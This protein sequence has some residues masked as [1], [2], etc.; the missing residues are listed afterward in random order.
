MKRL[1]PFVCLSLFHCAPRA[2]LEVLEPAD[3]YVPASIQTIA[4][5]DRIAWLDLNHE[6]S[7]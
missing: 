5:I 6:F 3:I 1:L 4:V 7:L 2:Y